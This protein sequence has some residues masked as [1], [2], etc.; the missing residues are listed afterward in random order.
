MWVPFKLQSHEASERGNHCDWERRKEQ[1]PREEVGKESGPGRRDDRTAQ[2]DGLPSIRAPMSCRSLKLGAL[3]RT[4]SNQ[5]CQDRG[6][7]SLIH[8]L[9][10]A[11]IGVG[12]WLHLSSF[13]HR[14]GTRSWI[15]S[16]SL[17]ISRAQVAP[18]IRTCKGRSPTSLIRGHLAALCLLWGR[19][20]PAPLS[21]KT[22]KRRR[23]ETHLPRV[24][25]GR[26]AGCQ[27]T[28]KS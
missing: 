26:V 18:W 4:P 22:R 5:K 3:L 23:L 11:H 25:Q 6:P 17:F 12:S 14:L 13:F 21:P 7:N 20:G 28:T 19:R 1:S 2:R 16:A 8:A 10:N 9:L 27:R 24:T 15:Q